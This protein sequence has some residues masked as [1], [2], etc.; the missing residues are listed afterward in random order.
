MDN[1]TVSNGIAKQKEIEIVGLMIEKYC[2]GNHCTKRGEMCDDCKALFEYAK[3]RRN[4]CPHGENKPFCSNCPIH[5]YKPEMKEKIRLVMRY[6]GPRMMTNHP[7]LAL[8]HLIQSKK[9]QR[10]M[11]M[12]K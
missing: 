9:E 5:C 6:S 3:Q 7:I 2:R 12:A 1:N 8:R 4:K 11:E 10:K